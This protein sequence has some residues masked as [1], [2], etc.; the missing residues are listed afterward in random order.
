[1]QLR[2]PVV[3][4]ALGTLAASPLRAAEAT[5]TLTAEFNGDYRSAFA[6]ENL[7]GTMRVV[8]G[9]GDK[10]KVTAIVHAESDSLAG[11]V[12]LVQ[13]AGDKGVPTLRV[14]YPNERVFR[15]PGAGHGSSSWSWLE[16]VFASGT[17]T[18]YDGRDV[19]VSGGDGVLLYADVQVEVPK[20]N[21]YGTFK[22]V[23][24]A[25]DG[26]G[27][28]G[29]LRFDTG[30]GA[31]KVT[32]VGGTVVADT[33]SG[34]VRASDVSGRF[35]CD[36]GSGECRVSGFQ[37]D[38]LKADTGSGTVHIE[39]SKARHISADTGSG[40]VYVESSDTEDFSADTGSGRVEATLSGTALRR[41]K[42]DT[43]SGSVT[44]RMD[45]A[46]AFEARADQG[47]G[48]LVSRFAD[49]QP[50]VHDREVIGY[51]RGDGH[52]RID[53]DTGSGDVVLEPL[54]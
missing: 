42:A 3:L 40:D 29:T 53:V 47:S 34:D 5:R 35:T 6:I 54:R 44:L 13:V 50:I 2:T 12:S 24:G 22:Q 23:V 41:V 7:A 37:G 20:A 30:S 39:R 8:G 28:Q 46:T 11:S 10:V 4:F 52:T 32:G 43:G 31:I 51:R 48:H 1:M 27:V 16:S 14:R 49:A 9:G 26:Q 38:A 36:T 33:G 45:P 15:Y 25:V 21:V 18:H 19:R 17:H